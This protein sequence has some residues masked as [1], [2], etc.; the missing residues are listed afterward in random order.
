MDEDTLQLLVDLH[1]NNERQGPGSPAT[2]EK[3]LTKSGIDTTANVQIADIGCG[4][5]SSTIP[6]LQ[7]TNAHVTAV[8]FLPA[9]LKKL[10]AEAVTAG[11]I[12]RLTTL[13]A[14]MNELPFRDEQFDVIWEEGAVYNIG[15]KHGITAWRRFLKP[16][17]VLVVSEITWLQADVPDEL[18]DHWQTEYPE[19]TTADKKIE[20]LEAAGYELIHYFPLESDAWLTYYYHPLSASFSDFLIRHDTSAAAQAI[21]SSEVKEITLYKKY[22]DY[23]SYGMY[24]AKRTGE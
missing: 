24:I 6:L 22:Q 12:D 23:V 11:V 8:D 14:D 18:K 7:A 9:F 19:V 20:Q 17:G 3:A 13:A 1:I 5:G 16:D 15:F 4:T 2:F 21:V 10:E